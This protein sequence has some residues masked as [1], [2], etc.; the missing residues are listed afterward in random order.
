RR[1]RGRRRTRSRARDATDAPSHVSNMNRVKGRSHS[2]WADRTVTG[3]HSPGVLSPI[4]AKI[5]RVAI[6]PPRG[7]EN[8][9]SPHSRRWGFHER[10]EQSSVRSIRPLL[11]QS[12]STFGKRSRIRVGEGMKRSLGMRNKPYS[13]GRALTGKLPLWASVIAALAI[14]ALPTEALAG[15]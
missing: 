14:A 8:A 5:L 12:A 15:E 10:G 4:P 6:D 7:N 13:R 2:H 9:G 11:P 1:R 3:R